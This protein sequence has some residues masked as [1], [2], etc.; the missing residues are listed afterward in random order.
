MAHAYDEKY[1]EK[2]TYREIR[3]SPRNRKRIR[4]VLRYETSGRL[5][6]IGCA[7][8]GFLEQA[9]RYFDVEGADISE[10]AVRSLRNRLGSRVYPCDIEKD[11][12]RPG[13]YNVIVAF[14]VLEHLKDPA[15]ALTKIRS[16]LR[17]GG[18]FFGSV[19]NNG[20]PVGRAATLVGNVLDRSHCSTWTPRRWESAFGA[21]GFSGVE[22]FGE[23][24]RGRNH[25]FYVRRP[26]WKYVSICLVFACR[27]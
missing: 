24:N 17:P 18:L 6:E 8:G 22:F 19:P 25:G 9:E 13:A 26:L 1:F 16:G 20:G 10:Y 27:A 4:E 23:V 7:Q 12:L 5:L 3:N 11:T 14:N 21:A 2:R 15:A